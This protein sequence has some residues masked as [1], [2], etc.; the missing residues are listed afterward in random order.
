MLKRVANPRDAALFEVT[1]LWFDIWN[2]ARGRM[3]MPAANVLRSTPEE[4]RDHLVIHL[5]DP[6][7][8]RFSGR[9]AKLLD[10]KLANSREMLATDTLDLMRQAFELVMKK[11][12]AVIT[13]TVFLQAGLLVENLTLPAQPSLE[14][15]GMCVSSI[16]AEPLGEAHK[17][18][19]AIEV[20]VLGRLD[21]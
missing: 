17:S 16:T 18:R 6:T 11:Q 19:P 14:D 9:E 21:A 7:E 15:R 20:V 8:H 10:L 3:V 2:E 1:R 13:R 4:I 5:T 12:E